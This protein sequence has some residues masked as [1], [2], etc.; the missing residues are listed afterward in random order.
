MSS[1][2]VDRIHTTIK[3]VCRIV[4][5]HS[6][7]TGKSVN[8]TGANVRLF[9]PLHSNFSQ[10]SSKIPV[11]SEKQRTRAAFRRPPAFSSSLSLSFFCYIV[12]SSR[13]SW[14]KLNKIAR[15]SAQ[16]ILN[17]QKMTG[18]RKAARRKHR[19]QLNF[20]KFDSVLCPFP[21]TSCTIPTRG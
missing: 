12:V 10:I 2:L 11:S 8:D 7:A 14:Y 16:T 3:N 18:D 15:R 5:S 6:F 19:S 9:D 20:V 4:L 1:I 21:C 13:V 17:V